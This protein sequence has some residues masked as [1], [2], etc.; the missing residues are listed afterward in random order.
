MV[1]G[2]GLKVR[3]TRRVDSIVRTAVEEGM[4]GIRM[5]DCNSELGRGM[6]VLANVEIF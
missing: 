6:E 2:G 4:M 1:V 5:K 3:A